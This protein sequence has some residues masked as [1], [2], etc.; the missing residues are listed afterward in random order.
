MVLASGLP[1]QIVPLDVTSRVRVHE[2]EIRAS[3]AASAP[4]T[5]ALGAALGFPG[6]PD[7][8]VHDAVA[9]A[10]LLAPDVLDFMPRR[11]KIGESGEPGGLGLRT[12]PRGYALEVA[13]AVRVAGVRQL[14]GRVLAVA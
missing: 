13:T 14:L 11:L 3:C 1:T 5:R 8:A 9:V 10:G 2:G 6:G 7:R 12:D 4:L